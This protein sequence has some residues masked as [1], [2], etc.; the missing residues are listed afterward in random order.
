MRESP[1]MNMAG[2]P[3]ALESAKRHMRAMN[4]RFTPKEC[5]ISDSTKAG[6]ASMKH[7]KFGTTFNVSGC[8]EETNNSSFHD[9]MRINAKGFMD[10]AVSHS[11]EFLRGRKMLVHHYMGMKKRVKV[12]GLKAKQS[13]SN[14]DD[15]DE[16]KRD[17]NVEGELGG[18]G[19]LPSKASD[20][21]FDFI[22]FS[23][24][25]SKANPHPPKHN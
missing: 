22:P 19:G 6:L 18:H 11:M 5:I 8:Y 15:G 13:V 7:W 10:D 21:V 3:A 17:L 2:V 24:D 16:V 14:C 12:K 4:A 23:A 20:D 9:L 1:K 25:Y